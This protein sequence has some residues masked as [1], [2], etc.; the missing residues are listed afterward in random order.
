[1]KN[2][3]ITLE[4]KAKM[5]CI[6]Y[7]MTMYIK[8]CDL[9]TNPFVIR[10]LNKDMCLEDHWAYI[11]DEHVATTAFHNIP[12][13]SGPIAG[14]SCDIQH[15]FTPLNYR[16]DIEKVKAAQV[17]KQRGISEVTLADRLKILAQHGFF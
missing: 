1:M 5:S 7:A 4:K 11:S 12:A 8:R 14:L 16:V 17:L 10:L 15:L 3:N 2:L 13:Y 6:S 9:D